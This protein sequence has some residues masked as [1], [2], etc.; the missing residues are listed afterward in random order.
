MQE[1][2]DWSVYDSIEITFNQMRFG[3]PLDEVSA[4]TDG[5]KFTSE[6]FQQQ[7]GCWATHSESVSTR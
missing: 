4:D 1:R 2:A 7:V 3:S 5:L 6:L